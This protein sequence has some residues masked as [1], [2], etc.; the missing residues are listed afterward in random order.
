MKSSMMLLLIIGGI[1]CKLAISSA[2]DDGHV[3]SPDGTYL[4]GNYIIL[5]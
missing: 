5:I 3:L 1:A 2:A 4:P